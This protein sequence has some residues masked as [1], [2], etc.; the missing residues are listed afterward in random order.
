M[1]NKLGLFVLWIPLVQLKNRQKQRELFRIIHNW[2]ED[3]AEWFRTQI[4]GFEGYLVIVLPT[5]DDDQRIPTTVVVCNI[6]GRIEFERKSL[7]TDKLLYA[8]IE[9]ELS[10]EKTYLL[11]VVLVERQ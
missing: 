2:V 1:R 6:D 4:A 7:Q 11:E 5:I 8:I 10:L 3:P 9:S